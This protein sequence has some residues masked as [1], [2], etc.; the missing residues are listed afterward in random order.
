MPIPA[1]RQSS[2][3]SFVPRRFQQKARPPGGPLM[4]LLETL[5]ISNHTAASC[6]IFVKGKT[7]GKLSVNFWLSFLPGDDCRRGK[8]SCPRNVA[9]REQ[10][11]GGE[12]GGDGGGGE[13]SLTPGGGGPP[14]PV[15]TSTMTPP[16]PEK[17]NLKKFLTSSACSDKQ[18][19]VLH[20]RTSLDGREG[21]VD[22]SCAPKAPLWRLRDLTCA[23]VTRCRDI[24][25]PF[26]PVDGSRPLCERPGAVRCR[27]GKPRFGDPAF[28]QAAAFCGGCPEAPGASRE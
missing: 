19:G 21:Q 27:G 11:V 26:Q 12:V 14:P 7:L 22:L 13:S 1:A 4:F 24:V 2:P 10:D 23:G 8:R 25:E 9:S 17:T 5:C 28:L 16:P 6:F 18:V 15:F 20:G 3:C